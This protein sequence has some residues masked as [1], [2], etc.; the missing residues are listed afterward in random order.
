M[1]ATLET[2][3]RDLLSGSFLRDAFDG[4][5]DTRDAA[6]AIVQIAFR[7]Q[8]NR[9]RLRIQSSVNQAVQDS[10]A[11]M[12]FY[13]REKV[14]LKTSNHQL[15]ASQIVAVATRFLSYYV[16]RYQ[17]LEARLIAILHRRR[18]RDQLM[19]MVKT[20]V[21]GKGI[22]LPPDQV[23]CRYA[24]NQTGVE[25]QMLQQAIRDIADPS[26]LRSRIL[27]LLAEELIPPLATI[28]CRDQHL[29][30]L[31]LSTDLVA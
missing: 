15:M 21:K 11:Q 23:I 18:F 2:P 30:K 10:L 12:R 29:L 16:D 22:N 25:I 20:I 3:D 9:V 5:T 24:K 7:A 28:I 19:S 26:R 4:G 6:R 13:V 8:I 17:D 14:D 27:D 1:P 31:G